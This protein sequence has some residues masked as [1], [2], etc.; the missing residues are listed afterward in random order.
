MEITVE[1]TTVCSGNSNVVMHME[2]SRPNETALCWQNEIISSV[3]SGSAFLFSLLIN[4]YITIT[5]L[6]LF[7]I[8]FYFSNYLWT[9]IEN[10]IHL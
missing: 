9:E 1:N 5:I 3:F 4:A 2:I 8:L 7:K 10:S 6:V